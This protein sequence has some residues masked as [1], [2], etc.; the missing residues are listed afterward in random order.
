MA[1][2]KNRASHR[3]APAHR[4]QVTFRQRILRA[5]PML[6]V[7]MLLSLLL[8][9]EGVFHRLEARALD[10]ETRLRSSMYEPQPS[11]VA[12]VL[13]G[14]DEYRSLFGEQSPLDPRAL[15]RLVAAV[16]AA[17]PKVIGVDVDTSPQVFQGLETLSPAFEVPVIWAQTAVLSRRMQ[18]LRVSD[19]LGR[20]T[21]AQTRAGLIVFKLDSDGVLRLYQRAY[22][23][24]KG[25]RP[26][27]PWALASAARADRS[28]KD[29]EED[30]DER[31]IAFDL[32][33]QHF[34]LYASKV[35]E[36][37]GEE[38]W[39]T[40]SP[41]KDKIVLIGGDYGVQDE[42]D[43]PLGWKLGVEVLAQIVDTELLL[44]NGG[45]KAAES[46]ILVPL[47]LCGGMLLLLL[48]YRV[49][50]SRALLISLVALPLLA[51]L[52]SM[53]A[54]WTP[55]SW[56]YFVPALLGIVLQEL[57]LGAWEIRKSVLESL[58]KEEGAHPEG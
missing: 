48:F 16:A 31:F 29:W 15:H 32:P 9:R 51:V 52:S 25:L 22:R 41:L 19:V 21:S 18:R 54:Y 24:D 6:S 55:S 57:F 58:A 33:A 44:P 1:K 53:L 4:P 34:V 40:D 43:T 14:D 23:T 13:I 3:G 38:G 11:D 36:L 2:S 27:L 20:E 30:E 46:W 45:R 5:A 50:L 35:L 12:L 39:R 56:T 42:H 7:A 49:R 47:Q 17:K 37:A 28:R 10:L 26:S 8:N